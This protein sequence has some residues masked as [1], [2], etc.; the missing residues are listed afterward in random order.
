MLKSV[1][2]VSK[3]LKLANHYKQ[4]VKNFTR[5]DEERCDVKLGREI[6]ESI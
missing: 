2:D 5:V 4:F 1:K 3:F 6:A